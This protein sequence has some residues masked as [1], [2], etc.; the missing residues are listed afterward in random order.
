MGNSV[1]PIPLPFRG[2]AARTG[3]AQ[4]ALVAAGWGLAPRAPLRAAPLLP[5]SPLKRSEG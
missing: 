3:T 1:I 5:A 2:G 4:R